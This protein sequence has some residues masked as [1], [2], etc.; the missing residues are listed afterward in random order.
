[1]PAPQCSR[2]E[3]TRPTV[4]VQQLADY[5]NSCFSCVAGLQHTS[6]ESLRP[7]CRRSVALLSV[8]SF[9]NFFRPADCIARPLGRWQNDGQTCVKSLQLGR[10]SPARIFRPGPGAM[11]TTLGTWLSVRSLRRLF[12]FHIAVLSRL[13]A[14][15]RGWGSPRGLGCGAGEL[16]IFLT[17]SLVLFCGGAV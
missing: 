12:L 2:R 5:R 9:F 14:A 17:G 16:A 8:S 1:M 10:L 11:D 15:A 3:S 7:T 6:A 4:R 13:A